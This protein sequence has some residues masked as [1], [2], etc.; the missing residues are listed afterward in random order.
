MLSDKAVQ[1]FKNIFKKKYGQELTD[2]EARDQ[3]QRLMNFVEII[4]DQAVIEHRRKLRLK[5]DKVKGFFLDSTE[6]PYTC[7]ICRQNYPGNE[8]WW[9]PKGLRCKDCWSN[10]QKKVIPSLDYDSDDKVWIKEWQFHYDYGLHP[11]TRNKLRREGLLKGRDL[12][13]SDGSIYCT[14]YLI[15]ENEEFLRKY[16]KKP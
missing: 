13:K 12:K 5:K 9:D 6:G 1:E 15:S 3:G 8:I 4:Y 14:V 10:I 11:A 7:A 16:P 2:A